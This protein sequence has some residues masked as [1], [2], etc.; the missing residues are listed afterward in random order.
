MARGRRAP[1]KSDPEPEPDTPQNENCYIIPFN[2]S[3]ASREDAAAVLPGHPSAEWDVD[4]GPAA[5]LEACAAALKKCLDRMQNVLAQLRAKTVDDIHGFVTTD[6]RTANPLMPALETP[7]AVIS[8]SDPGLVMNIMDDLCE[9]LEEDDSNNVVHLHA[10]DCSNIAGTLKALIGSLVKNSDESAIRGGASSDLSVLCAWLQSQNQSQEDGTVRVVVLFHD[11]EMFEPTVLGELFGICSLYAANIPFVFC[12]G[13]SARA[14]FLRACLPRAALTALHIRKFAMAQTST[15]VFETLIR[16]LYFDPEFSPDV[17]LGPAAF[18]LLLDDTNRFNASI[19]FLRSTLRLVH[20]HH[21]AEPVTSFCLDE[22]LGQTDRAHAERLLEH[23]ESIGFRERLLAALDV[24]PT[25]NSIVSG[26]ALL[27]SVVSA[28]ANFAEKTMGLRIAFNLL[29]TLQKFLREHQFRAAELRYGFGHLVQLCLEG[30][31]D[32][33]AKELCT[34]VLKL[35]AEQLQALLKL[36]YAELRKLPPQ[37]GSAEQQ[38]RTRILQEKE[39][40][41]ETTSIDDV[42]Q[43]ADGVSRLLHEYFSERLV[44]LHELPLC[45]AWYTGHTTCSPELLNANP[46]ASTLASLTFPYAVAPPG[47]EREPQ[48]QEQMSDTSVLFKRYLDSGKLINIHDWYRAFAFNL[49]K[50]ERRVPADTDAD[51]DDEDEDSDGPSSPKRRKRGSRASKSPSKSPK[52]RKKDASV[53]KWT[54]EDPAEWEAETKARFLR[55]YHELE[56]LGFIRHTRR[57]VEHVQ[58]TVFDVPLDDED[59]EQL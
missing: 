24:P 16:K 42:R 3:H 21:F 8:G 55:S 57:K 32:E 48:Q 53:A 56:Y 45:N 23:G 31:L 59:D 14:D 18:E 26:A 12:L 29:E 11:V 36:L 49:H 58:R 2:T 1:R 13:T 50:G 9:R 51:E 35:S 37:N 15:A 46:R 22:L 43:A 17:M 30:T 19:E 10:S 44:K 28:R 27:D 34:L 39:S 41:G 38:L 54:E 4:G 33:T 25:P 6:R 20:M 7:A 47:E 5:R 52:K 40:V